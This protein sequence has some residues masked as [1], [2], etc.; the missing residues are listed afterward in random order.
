MTGKEQ[1]DYACAD[2][3]YEAGDTPTIP[4]RTAFRR[5]W[6]LTKG[7]R[8]LLV[9]V[10]V[11]TVLA[12]LAETEAI[13]LF[14]DLTDHALQKGS[15]SAFWDPAAKWLG[16]AVVGAIVAY[17]GNSLAAW[18]TERFV[19][20]LREHVFDHVQQLPPHFFQRHRQGTCCPG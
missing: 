9:V 14:G 18:V 16:I 19:M 17:A 20:R 12:A 6:S 1:Y 15:L 5:F 4:A 10:W 13:L 11:C 3:G 7:L 8:G 2:D